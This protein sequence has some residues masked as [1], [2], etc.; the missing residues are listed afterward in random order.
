MALVQVDRT[1]AR[2]H[3]VFQLADRL[4]LVQEGAEYLNEIQANA[5]DQDLQD[6]FGVP[7][8]DAA[9]FRTVI[10]NLVTALSDSAVNNYISNIG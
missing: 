7:L 9:G 8:A 3:D 1:K 2:A 10:G 5:T 4:R 6:I